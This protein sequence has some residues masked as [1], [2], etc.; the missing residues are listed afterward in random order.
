MPVKDE[1][2][3]MGF[4]L[5]RIDRAI[6]DKGEDLEACLQYL[7]DLPPGEDNTEVSAVESELVAMGFDVERVKRAIRAKGEVLE[8]AL[9][10]LVEDADRAD[11]VRAAASRAK[12]QKRGEALPS[13]QKV[14]MPSPGA[15][16]AQQ[17]RAPAVG[18]APAPA[19]SLA[20]LLPPRAVASAGS[21]SAS[22]AQAPSAGNTNQRSLK[23]LMKEYNELNAFEAQPGGCRKV[24]ATPRRAPF[25]LQLALT[26]C[27]DLDPRL[28]RASL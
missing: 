8:P 28:I 26:L 20:A 17:V 16:P 27:D 1:L 22:G 11:N 4:P 2:I 9:Q 15:N 5:S 7:I 18:V 10:W 14:Q 23:R 3:S 6:H 24:L 25:S 12:V 19:R 21:S 13:Q